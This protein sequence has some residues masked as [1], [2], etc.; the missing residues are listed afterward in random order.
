MAPLRRALVA[1]TALTALAV[2]A[3]AG[4]AAAGR[5]ARPAVPV[6]RAAAQLVESIRD[7]RVEMRVEED[8]DL[9]VREVIAYDFGE[10]ERHGILRSIPVRL[11]YDDRY[12]RVYPVEIVSVEASGGAS[13]R[14]RVEE[15]G[16]TMTLRIGDPDR[17]I[18][19][20]HTY[21]VAYRVEAA[22]NAFP[23]HDEL[24]WN[25]VGAEWD[26]PVERAEVTVVA[27]AAIEEV[28]C[29]AGPEG[30]SLPCASATAEGATARFSA[31]G[32]NPFEALT[33]VAALPTGAV[34]TPRPRL[35]ERWSAARAFS[36]RRD[37]VGAAAGLMALV[38][39]AVVALAWRSG[40]DRRYAGSHVDTV[41][42]S[43]GDA[44][45]AVP[46]LERPVTPVEFAPPDGVRPGQ[47]GTLVDEQAHPL[48]VVATV[49][50]LAVRGYLRIEETQKKGWFN[51]ADWTLVDLGRERGDLLPYERRLID[52]VFENAVG[53]SVRLSEL[54]NRFAARLKEVQDAL[55]DDVVS[56]KWFPARPN[57]VRTWWRVIGVVVTIAGGGLVGLVAR[58]TTFGIVPVPLMAGGL[59]L[60]ASARRMPRRTARGTAVLRRVQGF[61]RFIED[62]E[63]D[64]ARFAER[65]N[66][67][68]E[69]L[70][71]AVVFG[72]TE[73]WARAFAGLDGELPEVGWYSGTGGFS[74]GSFSSSMD[75]FTVSTAGTIASTPGGS[76]GSGFGG[77]GSSGGGGGGGGGGSW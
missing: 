14:Y 10:N 55:Y 11:R 37:S 38:V 3:A 21:T 66:L 19:G 50:D 76:G 33:V 4:A 29:F 39:A 47:V 27:P 7:Y 54:R 70:P 57:Q 30:S 17:T 69:Y 61:R 36:L 71:Y 65:Q 56:R 16:G 52:A 72:C 73:K 43:E 2:P 63:K 26:V 45:E 51:K 75:D 9:D 15:G 31:D 12:D 49:V 41:F 28:A 22:L 40:R 35:E 67:F 6:H 23:D 77:G 32:L 5:T 18:T 24:Y 46:L 42:G 25:A 62:S 59:L 44:E 64:R 1:V 58:Y 34:P 60:V 53:G 74:V 48:D 68:S 20:A 8:G 13:A